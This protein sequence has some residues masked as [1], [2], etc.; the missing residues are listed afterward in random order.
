MILILSPP[1][2]T[3]FAGVVVLH[4]LYELL[5][6]AGVEAFIV[7]F[8]VPNHPNK[9]L[10][11]TAEKYFRPNSS[12]RFRSRSLTNELFKVAI[13][14]GVVLYPEIISGNPLGARNVVR[15]LLNREAALTG[16]AMSAGEADFVMTFSRAFAGERNDFELFIPTGAERFFKSRPLRDINDRTLDFFYIGKGYKYQSQFDPP[17]NFIELTRSWPKSQIQFHSLLLEARFFLS[18]D[19]V[20]GCN[21]EAVLAGAYP[22]IL[23]KGPV[24]AELLGRS[25]TPTFFGDP[26][27]LGSD[28]IPLEE[29]QRLMSHR[30]LLICELEKRE[31]S[32]KDLVGSL[33]KSLAHHFGVSFERILEKDERQDLK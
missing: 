13:N 25:E 28:K 32:V 18:Y 27:L 7:F 5:V 6:E 24:S 19:R 23:G 21:G 8:A 14:E 3:R 4:R 17:A 33:I 12:K 20:S 22:I 26:K 1:F 9:F 11:S 15:Y 29:V 10:F 2:N 30:A 16:K 31:A